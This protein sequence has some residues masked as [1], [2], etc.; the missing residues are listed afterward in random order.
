MRVRLA[1]QFPI[2]AQH[3]PIQMVHLSSAAVKGQGDLE[4]GGLPS[5]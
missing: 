3:F 1:K 4:H 2:E 5:P